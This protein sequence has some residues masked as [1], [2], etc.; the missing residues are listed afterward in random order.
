MARHVEESLR[1]TGVLATP[2]VSRNGRLYLPKELEDAVKRTNGREI[3]VYWE[4]VRAERAI[5][6]AKLIWNPEKLQVEYEAIIEDPRAESVIKSA[7]MKV[8]LGADYERI[9]YLDDLAIV[10]G[11]RFRE[12][13]LVAVPGI[14]EADLRVVE[15]QIGISE[16]VVPFEETPTIDASMRWDKEHALASL[17]RWA[18][19]GD[20]NDIDWVKYA[21]GFAWYDDSNPEDPQS[22]KLPHHVVIDDQLYVV[23][24]GVVSAMAHLMGARG[25]VDVPQS[26]RRGV[27]SHLAKH[28]RQFGKEVPS[29]ERL[30]ELISHV[31]SAEEK[32][33]WSASLSKFE[34]FCRSI[35]LSGTPREVI[36]LDFMGEK[37]RIR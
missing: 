32:G 36:V 20:S 22:Y 24:R 6:R 3:P 21:R 34:E 4:H 1:I 26:D 15:A 8:S 12:L 25:G 28:Y 37:V 13:S 16:R 31:N 23:W 14:P 10:R 9:D 30:A 35:G 19:K 5:G 27:Y 11:L 7:P 18:A 17:R 33:N 29:Y 2:R